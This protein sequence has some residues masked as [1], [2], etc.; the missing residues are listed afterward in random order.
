MENCTHKVR[1]DDSIGMLIHRHAERCID[2]SID[3]PDAVF[4]AL[5]SISFMINGVMKSSHLR[6]FHFKI[7]ST[8]ICIHMR[9]VDQNVIR[10][11]RSQLR[12][13]C[14]FI[15]YKAGQIVP[16]S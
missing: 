16:L 11:R 10:F 15:Q 14:L 2:G 7:A 4:F 5:A 3:D 13:L 9:A 6:D 1:R 8:A 12:V